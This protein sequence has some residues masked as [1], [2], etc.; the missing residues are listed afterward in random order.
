MKINRLTSLFMISFM[1]LFVLN[2]L[3][4]S[5]SSNPNGNEPNIDRPVGPAANPDDSISES[6]QW[7]KYEVPVHVSSDT[8]WQLQ[9]ISD[10]FNYRSSYTDLNQE[11][12]KRWKDYYPAQWDG[13][14][15]TSWKKEM[16]SVAEGY[17]RITASRPTD[18]LYEELTM[19][20]KTKESFQQTYTGCISSLSLV[21]YPVYVE[22]CAK[23]SKSTLASDV[24]MLSP[25][26]TQEI[27][28]IEAYGGDRS[29]TSA[30]QSYWATR[31]HLSHHLFI[32]HPFADYQPLDDGTWYTDGK[33]TKWADDF[34]RVGVY[35]KSP[36]HLEYY[37]DGY[38]VRTVDGMDIIDPKGFSGGTGLVKGLHIIINEEDQ[39]W[40]TVRGLSPTQEELSNQEDVT[41]FVDWIRVLKPLQK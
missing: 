7:S 2:P 35:W 13:P 39:E 1:M 34:H 19:P 14:G 32:R 28:I 25:D 23:L 36:T 8:V 10:E 11:F 17:L 5:C 21:T 33:G 37:V 41:F 31:L 12:T 27:D 9:P 18:A 15:I 22:A 4:T 40:R 38:L 30:T 3:T 20:D 29:E 24:W 16:V 26:D 6:F